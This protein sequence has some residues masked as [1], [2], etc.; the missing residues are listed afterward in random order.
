MDIRE[1]KRLIVDYRRV[2]INHQ[3]RPQIIILFGSYVENRQKEDSDIDV[4]VISR[5]LGKDRFKEGSLLNRLASKINPK[6]EVVPISLK[7]YFDPNN[8]S[9]ILD[10]IKKTGTPLI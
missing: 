9:P 3:I 8:I 10:Q 2:L 6:F 1:I 5:D 4:A 7:S